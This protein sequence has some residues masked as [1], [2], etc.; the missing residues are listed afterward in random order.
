MKKKE[1]PLL[2]I[3]R[4]VGKA[5]MDFNMIEDG[6][7]L[8][9]GISGGV[10]SMMLMHALTRLQKR[11]PIS[12]DLFAVTIDEGFDAIHHAP[13]AAYAQQQG[14]DLQILQAPIAQLIREKRAESSPCGLCARMRRGFIHGY[15]DEVNC[16]KLVLG[17]HRDDL[18]VSLLMNQ[19]RGKGIKTMSPNCPADGGTKRL[20]RPLCYTPKKLIEQCAKAFDF[21]TIGNCDYSE[22][23][24]QTGDRA[25]CERLFQTLEKTFPNIGNAMLHS[26]SDLHPETLLDQRF[27]P[28]RA[29]A[30][31]RRLKRP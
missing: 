19:F 1:D 28:M 25:T 4:L 3:G 9:V 18:C 22:Q 13:L 20:I 6:D 16:N 26:M 2:E 31:S 5:V 11:A 23:L 17:H 12:F 10:D 14:W 29:S 8:L 7:R 24:D 21:P 30:P 15:A 27:L